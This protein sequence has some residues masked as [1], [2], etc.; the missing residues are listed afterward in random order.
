MLSTTLSLLCGR[1]QYNFAAGERE[2]D[3]KVQYPKMNFALGCFRCA[4]QMRNRIL[5]DA[6]DCLK[7]VMPWILQCFESLRYFRYLDYLEC[8]KDFEYSE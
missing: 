4:M 1:R 5:W 6:L 3:T 7:F 8:L 2:Q